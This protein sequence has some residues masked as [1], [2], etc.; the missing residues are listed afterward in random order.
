MPRLLPQWAEATGHDVGMTT[1]SADAPVELDVRRGRP[2][3][4]SC[5]ADILTAT[6]ELVAEADDR[7]TVPSCALTGHGTYRITIRRTIGG[8]GDES[9]RDFLYTWADREVAREITLAV[10]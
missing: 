9:N 6:L 3:N 2:R 4:E 1:A 7:V 8:T 5:S 10:P